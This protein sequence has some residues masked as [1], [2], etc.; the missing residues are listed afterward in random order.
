MQ[1]QGGQSKSRVTAGVLALLLG[2]LG[3]HKFYLGFFIPGMVFLLANTVGLMFTWELLF[4]PNLALEVIA[5]V[6]GVTYLTKS[7]QEFHQR[8]V[9]EQKAWF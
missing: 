1:V 2:Y 7:P 5:F 8:Y 4:L 6:E 3:V 9:V